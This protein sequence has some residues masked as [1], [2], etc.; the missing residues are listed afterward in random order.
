MIL[1][2]VE[3]EPDSIAHVKKTVEDEH[4]DIECVVKN[5]AEAS[6]W[7]AE[8]PPDIVSLDLVLEGLS[9]EREVAGQAVFDKIWAEKFCPIII[10]S[11]QPDAAAEDR[12]DHP[13]VKSVKKGRSSPKLFAAAI[14]DLRPH[15]QAVREAEARIRREFAV[16]LREVAPYAFEVFSDAVERD[17]AILRCGRRRLAALMDNLTRH[18]DEECLA[19]WEHYLCPPV[20]DDTE[21]GDILRLKDDSPATPAAFFVVLTPSC[22]LVASGG[23]HPKVEKVLVA[24]CFSM[25]EA[26]AAVGMPFRKKIAKDPDLLGQF[27]DQMRRAVLTQGYCQKIIP[28][29][30][31]AGRIPTM[32]VDLRTLHLIPIEEI[33]TEGKYVRIAAFDSPFR[34]LISWAYLQIACRPAMPDRD[35]DSWCEEIIAVCQGKNKAVP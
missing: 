19:S 16:A 1:L 12:P 14:A 33:G 13:F 35:C 6:E 32:A 18:G 20:S 4:P 15:V 22:D 5:F 25:K 2:F 17:N 27:E 7:I 26:L 8:Q 24:S 31:L 3:D 23:R 30:R 21:L 34:E 10:Y 9:G 11:A 28:L 29:P